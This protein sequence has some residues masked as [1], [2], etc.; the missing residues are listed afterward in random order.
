[1]IQKKNERMYF[2]FHFLTLVLIILLSKFSKTHFKKVVVSNIIF[3]IYKKY[4][5]LYFPLKSKSPSVLNFAFPDESC[6]Y[7][8][9]SIKK[10]ERF[11][12]QGEIPLSKIH[13]FS[14][15][16]YDCNGNL[17]LCR[18]DAR[19]LPSYRLNIH[20][21][22]DACLIIRFYKR[23]EYENENFFKHLPEIC[24][25][26]SRLTQKEIIR[27]SR[28]VNQDLLKFIFKQ[29]I[30]IDK[31]MSGSR[32]FFFLPAKIYLNS[33]FV[34]KDAIYLIAL[35]LTFMGKITLSRFNLNCRYIGFMCCNLK[36]TETD[37]SISI[38]RKRRLTL[39][40]C[41]KK[42]ISKLEKYGY[43][44]NH[45]SLICWNNTNTNPVLL[46]REINL[47][48]SSLNNIRNKK[49]NYTKKKL[50]PIMQSF[51]PNIEYYE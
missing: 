34:N 45:D 14:L 11:I 17:L 40:F 39:W 30:L 49:Q 27:H 41:F 38:Q 8:I 47:S 28:K 22:V 19:L 25:K 2:V 51:Y 6:E 50:I 29:P 23:K 9:L 44:K 43:R 10:N 7:Y 13:Y 4:H 5:S 24:P 15:S 18:N 35:P 46:Y 1:M 36:S 3:E 20:C 26:R 31:T 16:F 12:L 42:D 32:H 37:S 21:T 48:K 33:M